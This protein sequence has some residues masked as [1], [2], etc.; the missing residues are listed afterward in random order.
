MMKKEYKTF[1][2]VQTL[3][4]IFIIASF[5]FLK[6]DYVKSVP[7]CI[8][9]EK[10]GLLCPSCYGTRFAIEMANFNFIEA[11]RLHPIFFILMVYLVILDITYVINVIFNKKIN[12]FKWWHVIIWLILLII[13]TIFRN[14]IN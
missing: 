4:I 5:I 8:I 6:S 9:N 13:Y 2:L 7:N 14:I 12:I 11:F 10:T 1:I 3:I